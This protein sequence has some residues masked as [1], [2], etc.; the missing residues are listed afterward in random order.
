MGTYDANALKVIDVGAFRYRFGIEGATFDYIID[1][2]SGTM[3]LT[4]QPF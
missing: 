1:G 2:K 4:R 3:A